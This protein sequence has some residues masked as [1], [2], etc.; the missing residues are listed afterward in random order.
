MALVNHV[1]LATPEGTVFCRLQN[2]VV[3]LD[4]RHSSEY[5]AKCPMFRG[6]AQGDGVECYWNDK[7]EDVK[8]PKIVTEPSKERDQVILSDIANPDENLVV[9]E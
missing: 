4:E 2:K 5:C 6:S 8:S 9:K 3:V 7:R 1:N